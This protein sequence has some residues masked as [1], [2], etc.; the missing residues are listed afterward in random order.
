MV[1]R[2]RRSWRDW[3]RCK[4]SQTSWKPRLGAMDAQGVWQTGVSLSIKSH[5]VL[6]RHQV[7]W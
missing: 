1:L 6:A 3:L 2:L 5:S 7:F 4:V